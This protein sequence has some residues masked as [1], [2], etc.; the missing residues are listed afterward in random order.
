MMEMGG[1]EAG[2]RDWIEYQRFVQYLLLAY[3]EG[4]LA[5][6]GNKVNNIP[7]GQLAD[8]SFLDDLQERGGKHSGFHIQETH[9]RDK[10]QQVNRSNVSPPY[11]ESVNV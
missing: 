7:A 4:F 2:G 5:T 11:D 8:V 9:A 10:K 3:A 6:Q 1:G